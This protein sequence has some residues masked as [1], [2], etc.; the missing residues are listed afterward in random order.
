M[1]ITFSQDP[2]LKFALRLAAH[3]KPGVQ[4]DASKVA[5][6]REGFAEIGNMSTD[7][8]LAEVLGPTRLHHNLGFTS[9][10]AAELN[11]I[12]QTFVSL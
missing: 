12:K 11:G 3:Q 1:K 8:D 10:Q 5:V 9:T 2:L 7:T 4:A 6:H